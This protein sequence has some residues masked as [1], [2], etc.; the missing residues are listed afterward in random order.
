MKNTTWFVNGKEYDEKYVEG[1]YS[2]TYSNMSMDEILSEDGYTVP[3]GHIF[4]L[5][6]NRNIQGGGV[7]LDSHIYGA[8]DTS[9]IIGKVIK[10]Y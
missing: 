2:D 1:G 9:K 7:S 8:L 5:G 3:K 10:I 6:D 4:V